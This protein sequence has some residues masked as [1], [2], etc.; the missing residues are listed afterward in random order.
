[1][2]TVSLPLTEPLNINISAYRVLYIL[3]M[4][5]RYRS[6]NLLE[7]NRHLTENK[8]IERGYNTE[9]L[10]KYINTL[11][12]V[13]CRIPRASNRNDYCYELLKNPFPLI[14]EPEESRIA[15]KVLEVLAQQPD[16]TLTR[17]YRNFLEHL[18]WSVNLSDWLQEEKR[19]PVLF[20]ELARRKKLLRTYR[21]Y[22]REAFLLRVFYR[23]PKAQQQ[24]V[25]HLLEPQEVTDHGTTLVLRGL[26]GES[27][28]PISLDIAFI[29]SVIQLPAKNRRPATP[30]TVVF[31]LSGRLA[32]SY[33]LYPEEKIIY[34]SAAELHIKTK[35]MEM[36]TLTGRLMK[37][38]TA[39][40]VLS[41]D[42][43]KETM[44]DRIAAMLQ[45]LMHT[46][47]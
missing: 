45:C 15:S 3:L 5:V 7:L 33:R 8:L 23:D 36:D 46:A 28:D 4:L 19:E 29:E 17:D 18:S 9:T 13:G 24:R 43:L 38:G 32:K 40:R 30:I 6:L 34:R 42:K 21:R 26:N 41:P 27:F 16:E 44:R 25:E 1:M 39:C 31:A 11:R 35:V 37:Y 10:S 47:P 14:I 2:A 20:P 12:E 22:C